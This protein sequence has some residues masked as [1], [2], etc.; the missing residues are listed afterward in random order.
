VNLQPLHGNLGHPSQLVQAHHAAGH[1]AA[2]GIIASFWVWI[3]AVMGVYREHKAGPAAVAAMEELSAEISASEQPRTVALSARRE[4]G[5]GMALA[6]TWGGFA[7][8]DLALDTF[9]GRD[10]TVAVRFMLQYPNAYAGPMLSV[11]GSGVWLAGQGDFDADPPAAAMKLQVRVGSGQVTWPAGIG[12]GTW[13]HLAVTRSGNVFAMYL[14]GQAGPQLNA[15]GEDPSGTLRIGKDTFDAAADGGGRQF[16]GLLDDVAVF[17]TALSPQRI[18]ALAAAAHLTGAEQDLVAGYVFGYV[19]PGGLPA[20]LARPLTLSEGAALVDVSANRDNAQD[21]AR[22]PMPATSL[23][24]LPFPPGA[25]W[26]VIQGFDNPTGS[27]R[28]YASFCHDLM[29]AGHPQSDS[30]GQQFVAAAPGVVDAVRQGASSGGLTNFISVRHADHQ[31]CD[32][33][34]LVQNSAQVNQQDAVDFG[35]PLARIGDTGANPGAF[36]LHLAMTNLGEA[37]KG[38]GGAFV[39]IPAPL[40]NYEVSD[41]QGQTWSLV[42]RGRVWVL[43][44]AKEPITGSA[45]V[46]SPGKRGCE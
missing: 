31:C 7:D 32:Y 46:R 33:L 3:A 4:D 45:G 17:G 26:L 28:G 35:T 5:C 1:Q 8:T 37:N 39:T 21:A 9:F 40:G 2:A 23:R 29:L 38:A 34:H 42:I 10:H 13:H 22:L 27:H 25:A 19:P 20:S 41:D 6:C 11:R 16:Y 44:T 36:H 14:D 15:G 18:A 30:N 12:A 24:H 43:I